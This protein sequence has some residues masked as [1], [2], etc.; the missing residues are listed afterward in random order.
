MEEA[1]VAGFE[2]MI[3]FGVIAPTGIPAAMRVG[4][5]ARLPLSLRTPRAWRRSFAWAG[6]SGREVQHGS[7]R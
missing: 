3:W 2:M 1:G 4:C 7:Q 5:R 6:R